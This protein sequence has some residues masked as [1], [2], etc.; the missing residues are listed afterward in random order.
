MNGASSMTNSVKKIFITGAAGFVGSC[1][2]RKAV[3]KGYDVHILVRE[4]ADFRRIENI[5]PRLKIH[6]GDLLDSGGLRKIISEVRPSGIMHLAASNMMSGIRASDEAL[7][8][9]NILGIVNLFSAVED[10]A[11]DFF[12][13][14]GSPL[15]SDPE[16]LYGITKLAATLYGQALAKTKNKPILT[17]RLATPYGPG[18]QEGRLIFNM[19][20]QAL[21]SSDL[22][23]SRPDVSRDF[24]FVEDIAEVYFEAMEK[25]KDLKGEVFDI[26]SGVST[27][28]DDLARLVLKLT[29]SKS[30][31]RWDSAIATSYDNRVWRADVEKTFAN[32]NWRPKYSLEEGLKKTIEW[33]KE[34]HKA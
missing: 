30:K 5:K 8:K 6:K 19:I 32:F 29:A 18:I 17:L 24:I 34:L 10:A 12:I 4:N 15:E 9:T 1:V 33:F 28:L 2:T 13:N 27:S 21:R 7:I 26:G 11:Y 20:S 16:E 22:V 31:V 3:E 25:A 23:L 14:T